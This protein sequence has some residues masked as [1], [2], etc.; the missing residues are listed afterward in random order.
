MSMTETIKLYDRDAYAIEF[1]ADIISCEPNKADDKQFDIILNQTLFFPEE[2]G[3]SPDMGILG[4]Y[5]VVD[6]QIKNGVITHT[7]DISAGDCCEAEKETGKQITGNEFEPEKVELAAGVHVHGKIDWQHRFYNM[8]QHSGEHIV[9][10]IVHRRFGYENVGFHL[11]NEDCTMDFNGE[12]PVEDLQE[13]EFRANQAVWENL[14]IQILY[15]SKEEEK[16][17]TYRSK[18]EITGQVRVVIVPGY[19]ACAC[20]A[21]HV[22][23]T[24]EIGLI[25]LV[26]MQRYKGGVRV[27]M[28]CGGRAMADYALKQKQAKEISAMLCAK[29]N[30]LTDAV[31]HLQKELAEKKTEL[32][33]KEQ[34]LIRCK[35]EQIPESEQIVCIFPEG[36]QGDSLR[37]L[38]NAVLE[39]NRKLCAVFSGNDAAGYRYVIGSR[40]VDVRNMAKELNAAFE[41]R[42]GGR[43]EMVQGTVRGTE[44]E[45]QN[46]ILRK[47]EEL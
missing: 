28:L 20:C 34:E 42:G 45:L 12:I 29:E 43:P 26:G 30:E 17:M 6:V 35:A 5:S 8:Q 4:G 7:V 24:G 31:A 37:I 3:Q 22:D 2:G 40:D 36:I 16:E 19:D 9:S 25:K 47:A 44:E 27:T 18:I 38:M 15:P 23:F 33:E 46:W 11:G 41:G 39:K 10:G 13:I 1:E 21:P 14:K 32:A